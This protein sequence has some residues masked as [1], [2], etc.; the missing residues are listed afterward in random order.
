MSSGYRH[1]KGLTL[2][3]ILVALTLGLVV[4]ATVLQIFLSSR[5]VYLTQEQSSGIQENGNFALEW[6]G[7]YIR[8]AGY[9]N[10]VKYIDRISSFEDLNINACG[11]QIGFVPGQ[12]MAGLDNV[13]NNN[14]SDCII[15][16]YRGNN[17]GSITDCFGTRIN[18]DKQTVI[19][20]FFLAFD[21]TINDW[22]LRCDS[23]TLNDTG[24]VA[25]PWNPQ[26]FVNNVQDLQILYGTN[27]GAYTATQVTNAN[28]WDNVISVKIA[29]LLSSENNGVSITNQNQTYV[30]PPWSNQPVTANDFRLRR[31]FTTTINRRN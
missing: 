23:T 31:V 24:T 7:K 22:A 6:L 4:T 11:Q 17:D 10:N 14:K 13:A 20:V 18:N 8:L 16:R 9:R 3:E 21:Q 27:T 2:V 30:F 26:T 15:F 12:V 29:L 19:N 25:K 5:Q 28:L 1:Q